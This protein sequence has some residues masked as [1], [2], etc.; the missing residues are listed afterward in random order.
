M[1]KFILQLCLFSFLFLGLLYFFLLQ[2]NGKHDD[3]YLRFTT[4]QQNSLVIGTSRAAQ[5]II[6][7]EINAIIPQKNLFNYAFTIY[8]SPFGEVYYQSIQ[9]KIAENSK[10][11]IF[12]FCID[13]WALGVTKDSITGKAKFQ[14]DDYA[15][16]GIRN[17]NSNP[18]WE[19]LFQHTSKSLF[20][21]YFN[22][23]KSTFLHH[24]G[25]LEITVPMDSSSIKKRLKEKIEQYNLKKQEFI[26]SETRIL[27]MKKTIKLLQTHGRVYLVRLPIHS[28][29]LG[30]EN[31]IWP[32]FSVDLM[33][34]GKEFDAPVFDFSNKS[35]RFTYTD[36]NHLHSSSSRK[37]SKEIGRL[38][39]ED[40][41]K[42]KQS[43]I[44]HE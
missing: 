32:N 33:S 43:S 16:A 13:P 26:K 28:E 17:V 7:T 30:M 1:R 44:T 12:I 39:L 2:I 27:W 8:H 20:E 15:L 23:N 37:I 31:Q 18:N 5:G 22:K 29:I 21:T 41:K 10:N 4:P 3:F 25:W 19:Y 40:L 11:G 42:S 24:D 34:W 6:P 9:R 35:N 14:E 38:I 36:G